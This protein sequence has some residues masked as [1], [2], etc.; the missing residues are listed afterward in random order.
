MDEVPTAPRG[1]VCL[2]ERLEQQDP[3]LPLYHFLDGRLRVTKSFTAQQLFD[4]A[5]RLAAAIQARVPA[6]EPILVVRTQ[7]PLA[8]LALFA[9]ILAGGVPLLLQL[10]QR[11]SVTSVFTLLRQRPLSYVLASPRVASQL[12]VALAN[13]PVTQQLRPQ[14]LHTDLRA[15]RRRWLRPE[16]EEHDILSLQWQGTASAD[17]DVLA[18]SHRNALNGLLAISEG[19]RLAPGHKGLCV[20]PVDQNDAWMIHVL[21]PLWLRAPSYFLSIRNIVKRP[22]IWMQAMADFKCHYSGAPAFLFNVCAEGV[23][24]LPPGALEHVQSLYTLSVRESPGG[25]AHFISTY[26]PAGLAPQALCTTYGFERSGTWLAGRREPPSIL[27]R[28]RRCLSHGLLVDDVQADWTDD[29]L[30]AGWRALNVI[31][32]PDRLPFPEPASSKQPLDGNRLRSLAGANLAGVRRTVQ[33]GDLVRM[34]DGQLYVY[35]RADALLSY[36]GNYVG[37]EDIEAT[38]MEAFQ[39]KGLRYCL[40]VPLP[41]DEF[42]VIA[43]CARRESAALWTPI[44]EAVAQ[45]VDSTFGVKLTRVMLLRPGSLTPLPDVAQWR[46]EC[47]AALLSG[48]LLQYIQPASS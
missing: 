3:R 37:A 34:E 43:E 35:G 16:R 15:D 5:R 38:I 14:I 46:R 29:G 2:I 32:E 8:V 24:S 20:Q 25:F 26:A 33:T 47:Q 45:L 28:G 40:L 41:R 17:T 11:S 21:M 6:G 39:H 19:L 4:E 27:H 1:L 12:K 30:P 7:G 23:S 22:E 36:G 48:E 42:V 13:A 44:T 31:G 10:P 9:V 18:L